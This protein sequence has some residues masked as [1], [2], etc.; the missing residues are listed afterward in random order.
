LEKNKVEMTVIET[1]KTKVEK[2]VVI[3]GLPEAGLVGTISSSYMIEQLKMKESG[4]IKS[5]FLPPIAVFHGSE[6]KELIRIYSGNQF[7]VIVSEI[8]ISISEIQPLAKAIVEWAKSKGAELI[9]SIGGLPVPNRM[10]IEKPQTYGA[11]ASKEARDQLKNAK[12]EIFEEGFIVGHNSLIL[13]ESLEQNIPAI[14]LMAQ[15]HYQYPDPGAAASVLEALSKLTKIKIDVKAL[16][17]KAEE[18]RVKTRELMRRTAP[19]MK[20]LRKTQEQELPGLYV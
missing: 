14:L 12:I 5:D 15:C 18:I 11:A 13:K 4:Y 3:V 10:D 8:P 17:E 9:I 19:V 16:E 7:F 6:L 20:Q 1:V 2:P